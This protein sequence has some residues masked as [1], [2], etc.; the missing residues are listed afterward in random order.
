[1]LSVVTLVVG[2]LITGVVI[3][4]LDLTGT[5]I[6]NRSTDSLSTAGSGGGHRPSDPGRRVYG[7]CATGEPVVAGQMVGSV[8]STMAA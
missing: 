3:W 5:G 6:I 8:R 7:A 2:A 4:V 1:L